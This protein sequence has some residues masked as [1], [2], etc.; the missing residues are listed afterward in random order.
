M[1]VFNTFSSLNPMFKEK[2]SGE[3]MEHKPKL[4]SGKRFKKLSSAL[5]KQPG[6]K[7]P[8]ALAAAIGRKKFGN[9]KMSQ[10]SQAGKK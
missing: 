6:I 3:K 2:Y 7:D 10:M 9:K 8:N 1:S 5:A 4:G